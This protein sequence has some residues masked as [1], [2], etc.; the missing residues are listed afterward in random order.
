MGRTTMDLVIWMMIII[1]T[2]KVICARLQQWL[3]ITARIYTKTTTRKFMNLV[4]SLTVKY[5]TLTL[6]AI[7][8]SKEVRFETGLE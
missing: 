8:Q 6:I 4:K 2:M 1:I 7:H 3:P 5:L